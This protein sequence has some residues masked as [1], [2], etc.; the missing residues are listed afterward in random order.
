MPYADLREFIALVEKEREMVR[1]KTEVDVKY[2]LGAIAR[3]VLNHGGVERNKALFFERLKGYSIPVIAG[4]LDSRKRYYLATGIP[5]ENFWREFLKKT[6]HPILP[7]LVKDGPCKENILKGKNADL[8]LLP[9][10]TLNEKDGGPY[11]TQAT[12]II[13]N[14]ETGVRNVGM[15][16]LMVHDGQSIGILAAEYRQI[17]DF[18]RKAHAKGE[19]FPVAITIGQDPAITC[20]SIVALPPDTDELGLAGAM[21]G[22]PVD[23][24]PCETVPLEVP[25]TAEIVIE[26]EIRPGSAREEGPF[27][28]YTGYYGE[29]M[30]RPVITIKAITHRNS[31]IFQA[32]YQGRPPNCD[33][34]TQILSHEAQIMGRVY[35]LGLRN[36][37][38]CVGSA[39]FM[40]IASVHKDYAGQERNIASAILGTPSGK[41]IKTLIMIDDDLDPDNWTEVEWALGTRFQPIEDT[42]IMQG[43][44]GIVLDPS[45]SSREQRANMSRTSK[46][47][48]D[49]TKPLHRPYAEEVRPKPDVMEKVIANWDTYGILLE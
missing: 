31:P 7:R 13:R 23:L 9:I 2:E 16:R 32:C 40:A 3:R 29:R 38:M 45:I 30:M 27:G 44:T 25:A 5:R 33:S 35:P 49:A 22:E 19:P 37:R 39:M 15:Y 47:I 1:V 21:R 43:M 48:I 8:S 4:L 24:V 14:P 18:T 12:T 11:I 36:I 20:S 46:I 34:V 17:N 28:E 26:G 10:P 41:W 6:E 42:I